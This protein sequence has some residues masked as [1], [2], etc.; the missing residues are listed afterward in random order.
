MWRKRFKNTLG[1]TRFDIFQRSSTPRNMSEKLAD[2]GS[3]N[4][5]AIWLV[6]WIMMDQV[7]HDRCEYRHILCICV[8]MYICIYVYMY[9]CI[10]V[11]MF[12]CIDVYVYVYMYVY[13][14]M[15][16]CTYVYMYILT[17]VY[18]YIFMY[19]CMYR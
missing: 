7:P 9:I 17:Y 3:V 11:Y 4:I 12:V 5:Q 15:Y 14:Y 8:F 2:F 18:I 19:I 10:Y 1:M 6:G 13:I 16:I